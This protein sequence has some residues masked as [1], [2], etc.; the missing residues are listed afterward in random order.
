VAT[1][2][3]LPEIN[4]TG[5]SGTFR[6][7]DRYVKVARAIQVTEKSVIVDALSQFSDESANPKLQD[8]IKAMIV[9]RVCF[10]AP[11]GS[12]M[13][14]P[15]GRHGGWNSGGAGRHY[16]RDMNWPVAR[17]I[18]RFYVVELISGYRGTYL[19]D[20]VSEFRWFEANGKKRK[21]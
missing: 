20:P 4:S 18:G 2:R 10:E 15:S 21:L 6:D 8:Q 17:A 1:I 19:W 13:L 11:K 5:V 7:W 16:P 14:A 3:A 12:K 9:L